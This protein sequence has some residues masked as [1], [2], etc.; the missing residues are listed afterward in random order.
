MV[1]LVGKHIT[2]CEN[3]EKRRYQ[4]RA[5][6]RGGNSALVGGGVRGTQM[7]EIR[8]NVEANDHL[9]D[10]DPEVIILFFILTIS[11]SAVRLEKPLTQRLSSHWPHRLAK[12][13]SS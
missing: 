13:C 9:D 2:E 7:G 4:S 12:G 3:L 11:L 5:G 1:E 10:I 8:R 6:G